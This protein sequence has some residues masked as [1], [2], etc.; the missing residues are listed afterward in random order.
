MPVL[1]VLQS[2]IWPAISQTTRLVP[3]ANMNLCL[4]TLTLAGAVAASP[5]DFQRRQCTRL[6][7]PRVTQKAWL[8]FYHEIFCWFWQ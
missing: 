5:V 1:D 6:S 2:I 8:T 4:L 7:Y 3:S